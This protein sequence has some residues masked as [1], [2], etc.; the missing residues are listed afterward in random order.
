MVLRGVRAR[1]AFGAWGALV[2]GFASLIVI[3]ALSSA[4]LGCGGSASPDVSQKNK[5]EPSITSAAYDFVTEKALQEY[6]PFGPLDAYNVIGNYRVTISVRNTKSAPIT[7]YGSGFSLFVSKTESTTVKEMP[8][9][10]TVELL[11]LNSASNTDISPGDEVEIVL[12]FSNWDGKT[13]GLVDGMPYYFLPYDV[14][15]GAQRA[16]Y[17][18]SRLTYKDV[19]FEKLNMSIT[20]ILR[21]Q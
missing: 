10:E 21:S 14:G 13:T 2:G 6:S 1:R 20:N 12:L 19:Q 5:I 8:R 18:P 16:G 9:T 7:I 15:Y 11:S 4:I 17:L 3:V